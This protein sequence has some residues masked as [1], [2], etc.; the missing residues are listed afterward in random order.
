M[1]LVKNI[2]FRIVGRDFS[3]YLKIKY[4][5]FSVAAKYR[6]YEAV[7]MRALEKLLKQEDL[8][9]DGGA[10]FGIY[11]RRMAELVGEKGLVLSF[12][13]LPFL[14]DF[15]RKDIN[16]E[17][18]RIIPKALSN[19][20]QELTLFIPYIGKGLLEPALASVEP[21]AMPALEQIVECVKL[22]DHTDEG[23]KVSFIK[24]D[25]EGHEMQALSG[26]E[27]TLRIDR[28]IVQFEE[29]NM[30]EKQDLWS[31][32]ATGYGYQI[33]TIRTKMRKSKMN[34]YLVP[35]ERVDSFSKI[36][37]KGFQVDTIGS[38]K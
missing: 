1:I 23:R 33:F 16:Q 38:S 5:I 25:V 10:N 21:L 11:S 24:I 35:I 30:R 36:L 4:V 6:L 3:K 13:P 27:R 29:N 32:F 9:I 19:K 18:I 31:R 26:G 37:S 34:Y 7:E 22:D 17:N 20:N 2:F 12:E 28:P 8:A 15:M 14:C